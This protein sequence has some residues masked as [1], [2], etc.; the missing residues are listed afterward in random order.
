MA[1]SSTIY[2]FH[3]NLADTNRNL[4]TSFALTVARHP[5]ENAERMLARVLAMCLHREEGLEFTKGLSTPDSPDLWSHSADAQLQLWIEVGEPNPERIK[6]A[7]RRAQQ[8][9]VY[10]F[11]SKS[12][13]WWQQ[14]KS[15]FTAFDVNVRQLP[16]EDLHFLSEA[17]TRNCE[18]SITISENTMF[19]AAESKTREIAIEHLQDSDSH[20]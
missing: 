10:S 11:N 4:Y 13:V 9:W 20:A 7:V 3:I 14:E 17:L 6:K 15:A 2:K 19:V 16:W 8:V 18:L 12:K 5:S 1:L